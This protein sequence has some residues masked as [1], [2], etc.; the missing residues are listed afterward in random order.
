MM[1]KRK[2]KKP[3]QPRRHPVI[4]GTESTPSR[5]PF[6]IPLGVPTYW[7][8]EQAFAVYELID[9]LR[10]RVLSIYLTEIRTMIC[11]HQQPPPLDNIIIPEDEPPF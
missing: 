2:A 1:A 11:Q 8:P 7:T 4:D 3:A 5:R 10:E 6:T 9:E